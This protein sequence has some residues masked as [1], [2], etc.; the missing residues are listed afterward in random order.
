MSIQSKLLRHLRHVKQTFIDYYYLRIKTT[1]ESLAKLKTIF[2]KDGVVTAGSASVC[3]I[4]NK[5]FSCFTKKKTMFRAFVT[6]PLLLF[7]PPNRQ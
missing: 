6:E 7:W 2:K 1:I 4:S 5:V 3:F